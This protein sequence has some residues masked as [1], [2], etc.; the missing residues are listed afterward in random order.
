MIGK[1]EDYIDYRISKSMEIF[2]DALLLAENGRWNSCTN[3]LYYASYY[4]VSAL[5]FK[6]NIKAET[7]NGVKTQFF[8]NY[9]KTG[10]LSKE[11]GKLFAHL[12]DWRQETDYAD[13]IEFDKK[14][15]E[16]ILK[17]VKELND[18]LRK[19]IKNS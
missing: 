6:N 10:L 3:R 18:E 19:L 7:H 17:N 2:D 16:P 14:T 12:F 13:F 4:L 5:L 15:I 8:L 11:N 1:K 9:V